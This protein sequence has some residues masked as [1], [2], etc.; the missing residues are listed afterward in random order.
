[1]IRRD[2]PYVDAEGKLTKVGYDALS[3][4]DRIQQAVSEVPDPTGGATVDTE[5]RAAIVA[6]KAALG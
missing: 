4:L 5:A 2:L 6:I 1:M 3:V